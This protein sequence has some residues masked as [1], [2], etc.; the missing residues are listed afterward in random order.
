MSYQCKTDYSFG[1]ASV[2][3]AP[4][5][6]AVDIPVSG[7]QLPPATIRSELNCVQSFLLHP[8]FVSINLLT[9]ECLEELKS[10]MPVG[11]QFLSRGEF[12]PFSGVSRHP[13]ADIYSSLLRCYIAYYTGQMESWR[14]RM[15]AT[16]A[17]I[18]KATPTADASEAECSG[19]GVSSHTKKGSKG[20]KR[21]GKS[22]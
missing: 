6:P 3:P 12:D 22:L 13:S 5:I 7:T 21:R 9:V 8:K 16:S 1:A 10:D 11:H 4:G 2:C 20:S 17:S 19:S 18:S 14:A 15:S